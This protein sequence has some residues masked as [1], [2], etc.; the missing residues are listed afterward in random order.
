MISPPEGFPEESQ[1]EW[2]PLSDISKHIQLAVIAT[3]DQK[4]PTH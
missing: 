4:F 2:V 3:E 1:N